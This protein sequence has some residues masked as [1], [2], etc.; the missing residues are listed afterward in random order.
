[1][2]R[3]L[4]VLTLLCLISFST[5]TASDRTHTVTT[6]DYAT[7]AH[8]TQVA[9]SPDGQHVA[10]CEG[11]WQTSTDDR[12]TNLWVV[13]TDGK[14]SPRR[15]TADRAN[16]REPK[17]STDGK[18]LYFL[19]N[20]KREAEKKPPFNGTTQVWSISL[21]GGEPQ[22]ITRVDGGIAGYDL[23]PKAKV[24]AYSKETSATEN[25]D[26]T[27]LRSQLAK[28]EYGHGRRTVSEIWK[29]DLTTWRE[30]KWV[31]D[32]RFVRE[33]VITADAAR[34]AMVT[35]HDDSVIKSEGES[36]VDVWEEGKVKTPPTDVYRA[37]AHSPHAWLE[38]LTWSP[39]GTRFAFCSIFDAYPTEVVIGT[40]DGS[41]WTTELMK[42]SDSL[43]VNGYGSTLKWH[44]SNVVFHIAE[45]H[46]KSSVIVATAHEAATL[47][48]VNFDDRVV[49]TFDFDE[50]VQKAVFVAGTSK[51]LPDLCVSDM[52]MNGTD[53]ISKLVSLNPQTASWKLPTVM[54]VTWKAPDGTEVGGVLELPP[55]YQS[56]TKLPLVVGIHGGP[57]TSTKAGLEFDPHNGRLYFAARGYAV[58]F[59]NYRGSTGYGDKFLGQLIGN[60]NEIEVNDIIAGV[61]HL[62]KEGIADPERVGVMGWSNGGYLTNC[63]IT[64]KDLPFKLKAASSGASI[65]DTAMEWG[66][67]DEPAYPKVFKKGHPWETPDLYRKTS[68]S[69]D[70]GN[71]K[72]PTLIHVGGNDVRCP[73]QHSRMLYRALREYVKVPT[74]LVVYPGEPHGLGKYSHRKA[75]MDWDLAW[76]DKYL[77]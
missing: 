25:D 30:E 68:P 20:R 18:T 75:K 69:W 12:K 31:D 48:D 70:M 3:K 16:D 77:K 5:L 42:R 19:G 21:D 41:A 36:R 46:G 28:L 51:G 17:W 71:I 44:P 50:K 33:F 47:P 59:P 11:R 64:K 53:T 60:E 26:F 52:K 65:L 13:T 61:Q 39:D 49:Y 56:G 45:K 27:Q 58:L 63:L 14:S 43:H 9:M 38:N 2:L 15:L 54:H 1:M 40:K 55:D 57:T 76:F 62:V 7:L 66:I 74:E 22:P 24:I 8:V 34:L 73:P 67:N 29:L 37:K 6:D 4:T 35:A 72:T 32:N 23:A 10:Y